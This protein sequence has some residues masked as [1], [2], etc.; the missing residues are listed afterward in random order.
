MKRKRR[1]A[2]LTTRELRIT[3]KKSP[4]LRAELKRLRLKLTTRARLV[5]IKK[6]RCDLGDFV[7]RQDPLILKPG[8][9]KSGK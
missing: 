1:L 2:P 8:T 3:L 5:G 4:K 9:L 7:P 6:D